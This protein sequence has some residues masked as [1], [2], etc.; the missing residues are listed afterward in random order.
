MSASSRHSRSQLL[1][2]IIDCL[3][4]TLAKA[5]ICRFLTGIIN[6]QGKQQ[7]SGGHFARCSRGQSPLASES[8][9]QLNNN[10]S[11][12]NQQS[13]CRIDKLRV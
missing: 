9:Q 12:L 5:L 13:M 11:E 6:A 8:P 10:V 1:H 2:Y 7:R 3:I 4:R